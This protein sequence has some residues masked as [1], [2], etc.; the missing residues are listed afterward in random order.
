MSTFLYIDGTNLFAGQYELFGPK[1]RLFFTSLLSEIEKI[2]AIDQIYFYTSYINRAIKKQSAHI[3]SLTTAEALFFREVKNSKRVLFYK[4]HRSPT[5]GKEKGVDVHLSVDIVKDAFLKKC[6]R[7]VIMSGDADLIYPLEI[8]KMFHM[9]TYA[10]FLPN[11][12]CLEMAHKVDRSYVF[13]FLNRFSTVRKLPRQLQI[14]D[15][16]RPCMINIQGR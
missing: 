7:V 13:N 6:D 15:I 12:F 10:L 1:Q 2:L 8:A 5:S 4:G 9:Q 3:Q 14:V 11:R 16:K